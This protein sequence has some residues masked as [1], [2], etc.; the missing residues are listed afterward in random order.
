MPSDVEQSYSLLP[1]EEV[2]EN[3]DTSLY[4]R[5]FKPQSLEGSMLRRYFGIGCF[6]ASVVTNVILLTLIL[7]DTDIRIHLFRKLGDQNNNTSFY[8]EEFYPP[9]LKPVK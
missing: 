8:G 4:S 1:N 3:N 2:P 7:W 9:T 5:D 6:F